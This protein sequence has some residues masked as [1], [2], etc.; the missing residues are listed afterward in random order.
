MSKYD[1]LWKYIQASGQAHLSLSFEEIV[2]IAGT[3]ID[4]SF[5]RYKKELEGY[6]YSVGK[7]SM[8]A[9]TVAFERLTQPDTLVLYL[10][11]KGG[12]AAECEHYRPLFPECA[13]AGL[14]Y[15]SDTPWDAKDEFPSAFDALAKNFNRV[16]LIANSIG[17]FFAMCALP[18]EKLEI[19]YFI[20]PIVDMERLISDMMKWA[21]VSEAALRQA[22]TLPT[23][24]GETLSWEY[25]SYVRSH[26][27]RWN[28]PTHIL[29]G[30][31]DHL[32]PREVVSAF[33][34]AHH[35]ALTV[36]EAGEHWFHT[37]EQMA[38][39]DHWLLK[40]RRQSIDVQ[41]SGSARRND[42]WEAK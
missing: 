13:V 23:S 32:T 41:K 14:D 7:I 17:A 30:E 26:P 39:L 6:G 20:S 36:M 24:F 40:S 34:D 4:H 42:I 31:R 33:A 10:H 25:L 15:K 16:V 5:L 37:P 27:I 18:Q 11:G 28:V 35:A 8:K 9:Q 22:G 38:F 12:D 2:R 29:Y 3:P 1:E 19:A 21:N